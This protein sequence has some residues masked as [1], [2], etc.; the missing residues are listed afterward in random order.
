[1]SFVKDGLCKHHEH[2]N[3]GEVAGVSITVR[4]LSSMACERNYS[5][6][7]VFAASTCHPSVSST[8]PVLLLPAL[9]Y[10]CTNKGGRN[11]P[12][13][14]TIAEPAVK[15]MQAP[16]HFIAAIVHLPGHWCVGIAD[17]MNSKL[18]FANS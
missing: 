11:T 12:L 15:R 17:H 14:T 7:A 10:E 8:S 1:M 3:L 13:L 9:A 6:D 18:Y 4:L 2:E 5:D 16:V